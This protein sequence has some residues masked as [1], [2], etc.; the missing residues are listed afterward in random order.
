MDTV[1][2]KI[3][4]DIECNV[5]IDNKFIAKAKR[6][7]IEQILLSKGE[8]WLQCICAHNHKYKIEQIVNI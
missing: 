2:L 1:N 4:S 5:Y 6:N 7:I 8:Y 3:L